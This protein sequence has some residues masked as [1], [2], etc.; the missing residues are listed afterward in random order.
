MIAIFLTYLVWYRFKPLHLD[1]VI[2]TEITHYIDR[3][4]CFVK[5]L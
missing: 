5:S 1:D 2:V 3:L 4:F